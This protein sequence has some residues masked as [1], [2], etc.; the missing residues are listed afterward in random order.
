MLLFFYLFKSV[1]VSKFLHFCNNTVCDYFVR[2]TF[3]LLFIF[4][5][6]N[7]ILGALFVYLYFMYVVHH[8]QSTCMS[9]S[10]SN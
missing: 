3:E 7:Y 1:N 6:L 5:L 4:I 10:K 2:N 8:L 9:L